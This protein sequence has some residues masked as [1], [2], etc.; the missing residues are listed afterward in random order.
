MVIVTRRISQSI[1]IGDSIQ[2]VIFE[3]RGDQVRFGI[4]LPSGISI[5]RKEIGEQ[6]QE[7]PF[8]PDAGSKR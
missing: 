4:R 5:H 1:M 7:L 8:E 6:L 2:V 3:V